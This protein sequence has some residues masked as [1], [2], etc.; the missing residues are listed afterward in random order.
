MKKQLLLGVEVTIKYDD[1]A[2]EE[3]KYAE[4]STLEDAKE[5]CRDNNNF[6]PEDSGSYTIQDGERVYILNVFEDEYIFFTA[7]DKFGNSTTSYVYVDIP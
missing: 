3:C 1:K 2:L 7:K 6:M 5:K 4:A